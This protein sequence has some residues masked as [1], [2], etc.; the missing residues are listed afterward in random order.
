MATYTELLTDIK[1]RYR[2]SFTDAQVLVWLNESMLEIY[3]TIE[4]DSI[5]YLMQTS[6]EEHFYN[7]PANLDVTKI[8]TVTYRINED[9]VFEELPFVRVDDMQFANREELWYSIVSRM[10]YINVPG[11]VVDN[12][13]VF[14]FC[15]D[16]FDLITTANLGDALTLPLKYHEVLKLG[17]LERIA[18][19]RKDVVMK[20]N[21]FVDR[22]QRMSDYVWA[23]KLAEPEWTSVADAMPKVSRSW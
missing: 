2:H 4:L 21:Y 14:I 1:T 15:D 6:Y 16:F 7:L 8:K 9:N 20:N 5:P 13:P 10:F 19:A 3:D 23:S 17:V 22:E 12:I 11:G 18:G